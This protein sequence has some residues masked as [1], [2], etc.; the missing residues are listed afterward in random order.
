MPK[1]L[2]LTQPKDLHARAVAEA[3]T[4]RGV[5]PT[6]WHTSDYPTRSRETIRYERGRRT[7]RVHGPE[8]ALDDDAFDVVWYRRPVLAAIDGAAIAAADRDF[9]EQG[10]GQFRRG[11]FDGL[12]RDA[13]WVNDY[14]AALRAE[15]KIGQLRVAMECGLAAPATIITNDPDELRGFVRRHG[16]QVAYKPLKPIAWRAGDQVWVNYTTMV[17]EDDLVEDDLLQA[18]PGI[19]QEVVPKAF[20]VRLTMIGGHAIAARLRSQE[21]VAGTLDWRRAYDELAMEPYT[22]PAAVV[23]GCRAVLARLGLVFG[24]FDLIVTPDGRHVFL[25]VNQMGQFLFVERYT[26]QPLLDAFCELLVAGR[27]DFAWRADRARVAYADVEP[28]A[29]AAVERDLAV[30]VERVTRDP[31]DA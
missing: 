7:V 23:A 8:L 19:F 3:L 21:T 31:V 5:V 30:H 26:G 18:V 17:G 15:S 16:G 27:P 9:V 22:P 4:R 13:F 25:E 12:A 2:I 20:E 11:L 6:V 1:I 28:V 10:C 14:T 24:C 29:L